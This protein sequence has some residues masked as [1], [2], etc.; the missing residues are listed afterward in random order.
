MKM[1]YSAQSE[2]LN[3]Y[4]QELEATKE[5]F[6]QAKARLEEKEREKEELRKRFVETDTQV[7]FRIIRNK[8]NM[9]LHVFDIDV[10]RR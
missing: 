3:F 2:E 10:D 1:S 9:L 7:H 4:H 5:A 8:G 6:E